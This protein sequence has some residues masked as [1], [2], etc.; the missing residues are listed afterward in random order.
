MNQLI[1]IGELQN[2]IKKDENLELDIKTKDYKHSNINVKVLIEEGYQQDML[3]ALDKKPL[4]AIKV[5]FKNTKGKIGF[6]AEK[7]SVLKLG[8]EKEINEQKD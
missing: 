4:L 1:I 3:S 5:A 7:M 2:Y 6:I 8:Q